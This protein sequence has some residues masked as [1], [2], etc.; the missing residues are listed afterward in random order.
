MSTATVS[1]S[2]A[3]ALALHQNGN[4]VEASA[5][6][7]AT[8]LEQPL[9]AQATNL[10]GAIALQ[11]GDAQRAADLFG[12]AVELDASNVSAY[13]NRGLALWQLRQLQAALRSY[14]QAIALQPD[15]G[16][17]HFNRGNVLA[18]LERREMARESYLQALAIEPDYAEAYVRCA[19]VLCKLQDWEGARSHYERA[20][21]LVP[22]YEQAYFGRANVHAQCAQWEAA[23]AD[24]ERAVSINGDYAE[25]YSD[26]GVVLMELSRPEEARASFEQA[27]AVDPRY[28]E[29]HNNLGSAL[30]SLGRYEEAAACYREALRL[31]PQY[32]EAYS[33]LGGA[34]LDL[35]NAEEAVQSYRQALQFRPQ[36]VE[37]LCNLGVALRRTGQTRKAA[38][39]CE[40]AL[41][42]DPGS[43]RTLTVLGN[44]RADQGDFGEAEQ[45]YRRAMAID[46]DLP[47]AW[48]ELSRLRRLTSADVAWL[49]G[50]QRLLSLNLPARKLADVQFALGKCFDDLGQYEQAFSHYR[51]ANELLKRHSPPYEPLRQTRAIDEVIRLIDRRWQQL[52]SIDV[53]G[54]E[55]PVFIVGM[56]R[57]GTTLA[58][59]ILASH[60]EVFG[61]G[62]LSFWPRAAASF[63]TRLQRTPRSDLLGELGK[64][65]LQQLQALSADASR[66]IDKMP[67]N[68]QFLGL[69]RS[70]VPQ[71]RFIHMQRSPLDTCLSI[72]FQNF[73]V[74]H[75][76]ANDLQDLAH[77]YGEYRR[78]MQHWRDTLPAGSLLEVPYEALVEDPEHWSRLMIEFIG[79]DWDPRCLDFHQT[80]R[81]VT[82][83]S[84]WQVRQK[85]TK[86]SVERWRRYQ[87]YL[88]PLM[89]LVR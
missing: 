29:A 42:I 65:Y 33:N 45:L 3:R 66:V 77:F 27:I 47:E 23:L 31:R 64:E 9:H 52:P 72:Y 87:P 57:S 39:S 79:L 48:T 53:V 81:T 20:I 13:C 88:A 56:P 8:L 22:G 1:D 43:A 86:S 46:P 14:D 59:Q 58:E 69:I 80:A 11:T 25:A 36:S 40:R 15:I 85:I 70:A 78:V 49:A 73:S 6:Y 83:A 84:L 67:G 12:R 34:L 41:Q 55:R 50:T 35:D 68:F 89:P 82:T 2:F 10:L 5:M 28:V 37:T 71:A 74:V 62:E 63:E 19:D 21:E 61:A 51:Q 4:L 76:Y 26:R 38:A 18:E 75:P 54:S 32:P 16:E 44:L 17:A 30:L 7:E 60:P 24:Y